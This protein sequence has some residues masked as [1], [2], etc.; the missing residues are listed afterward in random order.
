MQAM[1]MRRT[2]SLVCAMVVLM[3]ALLAGDARAAPSRADGTTVAS[4][5]RL[6]AHVRA[7]MDLLPRWTPAYHALRG[8]QTMISYHNAQ[9]NVTL[10]WTAQRKAAWKLAHAAIKTCPLDWSMANKTTPGPILEAHAT[11]AADYYRL[12][13]AIVGWMQD[14]QY[15]F[16]VLA[17]GS[18]PRPEDKT[19]V[20]ISVSLKMAEVQWSHF[21]PQTRS[22]RATMQ[23]FERK[24]HL[25]P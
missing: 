22:L 9:Y 15:T 12:N 4:Y 24:W 10:P 17:I 5:Y 2:K 1:S 8:R 6:R 3:S 18:P 14:A 23:A 13:A 21:A 11:R 19:L 20:D 7:C 16:G 25:T